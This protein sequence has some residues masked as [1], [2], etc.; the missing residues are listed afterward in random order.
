MQLKL[1]LLI[2]IGSFCEREPN[3]AIFGDVQNIRDGCFLPQFIY[4]LKCPGLFQLE[5]HNHKESS[6]GV[7]ELF[8]YW[9]YAVDLSWSQVQ[10]Q[11]NSLCTSEQIHNQRITYKL[12]VMNKT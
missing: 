4:D 10:R 8:L 7:E 1:S 12:S 11:I 9:N 5:I 3:M 6:L 2:F